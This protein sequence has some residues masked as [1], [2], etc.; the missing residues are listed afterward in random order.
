MAA[1][2]TSSPMELA[3]LVELIDAREVEM[4]QNKRRTLLE[5]AE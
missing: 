4:L 3:D 2:L 1:G 5:A